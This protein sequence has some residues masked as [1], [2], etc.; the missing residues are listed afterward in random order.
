MKSSEITLSIVERN[1]RKNVGIWIDHHEAFIVFL[2]EMSNDEA[3]VQTRQIESGM[4]KYGGYAERL[5]LSNVTFSTQHDRLMMT[6]VN[7]YYDNL[8]EPVKNAKSVFLFG[9][10]E[11]KME[12]KNRF[13]KK[14]LGGVVVGV[15]IA[16][17]M[18]DLQIV[19]NARRYFE[20][21][22]KNAAKR[23]FYAR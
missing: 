8:I 23:N 7:R 2:D 1:M 20:R 14:D 9:P 10:D 5:G 6:L 11:A 13:E 12:L 3:A 19:E 21:Q 17:S 15:E 4:E 22:W 16:D 18:T